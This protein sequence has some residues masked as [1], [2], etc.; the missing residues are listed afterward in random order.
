[1]KDLFAKASATIASPAQPALPIKLTVTVPTGNLTYPEVRDW[2]VNYSSVYNIRKEHDLMD[3]IAAG[4]FID[5]L[6]KMFPK[7]E[8]HESEAFKDAQYRI[9]SAYW[10]VQWV[11]ADGSP[12]DMRVLERDRIKDVLRQRL[13]ESGTDDLHVRVTA[14][15]SGKPISVTKSASG[16]SLTSLTDFRNWITGHADPGLHAGIPDLAYSV[17][18]ELIRIAGT[19]CHV[20]WRT[21]KL[22]WLHSDG[23]P[24]D[25]RPLEREWLRQLLQQR[26]K[27]TKRESMSARKAIDKVLME[28]PMDLGGYPESGQYKDTLQR[29]VTFLNRIHGEEAKLNIGSI[30]QAM[31]VAIRDAMEMERPYRRA[32]EKL[33]IELI[34]E[35]P[36]FK[37]F[38]EPYE[39]GEFQIDAKLGVSG[40]LENIRIG[41]DE[42]PE[43]EPGEEG[44]EPE[45]EEPE[46]EGPGEAEEVKAAEEFKGFDPEVMKRRIINAMIAGGA[47]SKNYAYQLFNKRFA[48]INPNLPTLYGMAMAGTEIGYFAMGDSQVS[49]AAQTPEAAGGSA[50]LDFEPDENKVPVIKVR[51]M[52]FPMLVQELTKG[53]LELISYEGLPSDPSKAKEVIDKADLA[54]WSVSPAYPIMGRGLWQRFVAAIGQDEDE[55]TAHLYSKLIQLPKDEFNATMKTIQ[56]GGPEAQKLIKQMAAEL[57]ADMENEERESHGTFR[58]QEPGPE[59]EG[60]EGEFGVDPDAWKNG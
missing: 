6:T 29:L 11:H 8:D 22:E 14:M 10:S 39:A 47:V 42:E 36:E 57:K 31:M 50:E 20:D 3:G 33:A 53:L 55:I 48:K 18:G 21:V 9:V 56:A 16:I 51:A 46:A 32:L 35:Q 28:M 17:H 34:F 4:K 13:G 44:E 37:K 24:F 30:Y 2:P 19:Q 5:K 15:A 43:E 49:M 1:M 38:K 60:G 12:W 27:K 40:E 7:L 41:G 26:L 58:E 25:M 52:I 45:G 23:T 54:N 59:P